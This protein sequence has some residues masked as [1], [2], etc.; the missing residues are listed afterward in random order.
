MSRTHRLVTLVTG[1]TAAL[2][3]A[4]GAAPASAAPADPGSGTVQA[5][6]DRQLRL[7]PD[8]TQISAN[9]IA[10]RDGTVIMTFPSDDIAVQGTADCPAGWFCFWADAG[11][12]GRRLQFSDCGQQDLG[13]WAFRNKTS[14]WQN[15]TGSRV[16]V[17][18]YDLIND[19]LW[20]EQPRSSSSWVGSANNDRADYFKRIC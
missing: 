11:F 17:W 3:I 9:Q 2:A 4:A 1:L 20:T 7:T 14:S 5:Q 13:D 15:T 19:K 12:E 6:I 18:Q 8:G 16:E 10:W